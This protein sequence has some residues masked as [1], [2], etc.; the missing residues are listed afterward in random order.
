MPD[1]VGCHT[2]CLF[3]VITILETTIKMVYGINVN[4]KRLPGSCTS[5]VLESL[6]GLFCGVLKRSLKISLLALSCLCVCAFIIYSN[7][8]V[9]AH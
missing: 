4:I 2:Q 8:F 7:D 9:I 6:F 1:F 5:Y 3:V